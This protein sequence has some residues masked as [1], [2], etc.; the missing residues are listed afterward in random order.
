MF[1]DDLSHLRQT[2]KS[3]ELLFDVSLQMRKTMAGLESGP[4]LSR[5]PRRRIVPLR[6]RLVDPAEVAGHAGV[7]S[8]DVRPSA[9]DAAGHDADHD[10]SLVVLGNQSAAAVTLYKQKYF[11]NSNFNS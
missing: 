9:A 7:D 5:T 11:K 10:H 2:R 1:Y 3:S 8:R 4:V 6:D